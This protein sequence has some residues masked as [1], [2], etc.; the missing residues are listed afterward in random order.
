MS[1]AARVGIFM[2]IILAILGYF[3]LKI[4]DIRPNRKGTKTVTAVFDSVAGLDN[5]S[6]VRVAGVPVG[7]VKDI[8][9]RGDGKAV[10]TMEIDSD[11]Q[12]R[13]GAFARVVNLG[14]LGEKYVEIVPG[15]TNM[16]E[17]AQGTTLQG[18]QPASID[19]VTN[20]ISAIA[21]DV[22]AITE[23]LR[24][25]VSG[26]Q[27]EQRLQAIVENARQITEQVRDLVATN[28]VNVDAT[29][30]NARE[31]TA[32]LRNEIPRLTSSIEKVA[33]TLNGT[34]GENRQDVKQVVENLRK[35]STDL[36]TS[37]EN[38]NAITG[39]VRSGEG[40]VGKL[41]YSDEAHQ[42]LNTALTAVESGVNELRTTLG[43]ANRIA[44]DLGMKGDYYAGLN[45]P[46]SDQVGSINSNSRAAVTLR[47]IP[48]P[49]RN[50]F[51]NVEFATDPI[52]K[53]KD[54]VTDLTFTDP[55][56]GRSVSTVIT[57]TRFERG[58]LLSAQAGWNLQPL[59]VRVGLFDS[60]GGAGVD[61]HLNNRI[62]LTGEAFDFGK[63][64][65]KNPHLRMYGQY[66]FRQEKP[67]MPML[68][69]STGVDNVL[70]N[71]AFTIGGGIRW[72]DD[73]LKYL[74]GSIPIS[75]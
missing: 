25:A 64:R 51:Y 53:R 62:N 14:L 67:N 1:S 74:L 46:G 40:T 28:R 3:I 41:L 48:N 73:D 44:L 7:E 23:S 10:V 27:G 20:Q 13:K 59:A 60:S 69:I 47:L 30:A 65:D 52:G 26:P 66:V 16:P 17:L 9:L 42:R 61:Y 71:T 58:F 75:K 24:T 49:E 54:K 22:K 33:N 56:T 2:L 57:E 18:S 68:F 39:Q 5:K 29:L 32:Q 6:K 11:I 50:R 55:A 4:E 31:I 21:T 43:R 36:K 8:Q 35:L 45:N 70:N 63:S 15:P 19:D 38:L 72:R 34:V 37:T 12:L